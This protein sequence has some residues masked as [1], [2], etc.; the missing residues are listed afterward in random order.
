[1]RI[2]EP[3]GGRARETVF[4]ERWDFSIKSITGENHFSK[5][6][7]RKKGKRQEKEAL[8]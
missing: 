8:K 6:N 4:P 7:K 1:M 2:H 3:Q 5:E